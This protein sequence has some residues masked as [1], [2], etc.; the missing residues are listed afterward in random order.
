VRDRFMRFVDKSPRGCWTWAG[1]RHKQG[2]GFFRLDGRNQYAHRM[3]YE[4]FKGPVPEGLFVCHHCDNPSCVNPEHLY[5]GTRADNARDAVER[6]RY[7]PA[8]RGEANEQVKLTEAAIHDIR[9]KRAPQREL[10]NLYG[11]SQSLI[12]RI[13]TGRRWPQAA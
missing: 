5:A 6:E 12:S 7:R 1:A 2:Y 13:Q 9:S 8:R 4:L 3:A 10:A 11:V